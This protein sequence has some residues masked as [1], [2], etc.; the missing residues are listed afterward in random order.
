[1]LSDLVFCSNCGSK[2]TVCARNNFLKC[3]KYSKGIC[4]VSHGIS[5]AKISE[6][7]LKK[8]KDDIGDEKI[9]IIV[10]PKKQKNEI[11]IGGNQL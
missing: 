10:N 7:I 2:L 11:Q 5:A 6:V 9:N 4:K 1:M 8:L 3:G